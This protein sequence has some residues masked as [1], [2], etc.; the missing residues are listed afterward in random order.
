MNTNSSPFD[1]AN[2]SDA[3]HPN[4]TLNKWV[5]RGVTAVFGLFAFISILTTFGIVLTLIVDAIPFFAEVSLKDFLTDTQ[6]TPLFLEPR[7]G[8]FVLVSATFLTSAIAIAVA[9]PLGLLAAI[10]LSEYAPRNMRR[11]L[12]PALE[13]L[14][15]V[16]SI[17]Y[18]YF[19]LL[20]VTPLL[21]NFLPLEPF[22]SLS[23]GAVM[24]I[25]IL[26]TIAS[27]SE[28][29]IYAVPT[30]LRQGAYAVGATKREVVLG[31][32]I[33]G[34]LSGIVASI[35]LAISRAVGATMIVT[36]AAG[37][38]PNLTLNP[39]VPVMTMTASIVQM[40]LGDAPVG[41]TE[42]KAIYA[43]GLTLFFITLALNILST[44][45]VRRFQQRYE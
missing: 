33:P 29:A 42:F 32:V 18:G 4:R 28:D 35:I 14:E 6:W 9:V 31:V 1:R 12:K 3:W 26:P 40:S 20:F 13:I 27:L 41:T 17:V 8:I 45:F 16:P 19:A 39:F 2:R 5:Q 25:A 24:G 38:N 23:A 43:I 10:C 22:N 37:I 21:S 15:G 34:A 44:W 30:S 7:F 11:W 36:V